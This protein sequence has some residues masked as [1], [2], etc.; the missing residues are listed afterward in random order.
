M[1]E[2][3]CDK[4][5]C[6]RWLCRSWPFSRLNSWSM[7]PD[8]SQEGSWLSPHP[9]HTAAF[10]SRRWAS[11][12]CMTPFAL[13]YSRWTWHSKLLQAMVAPWMRTTTIQCHQWSMVIVPNRKKQPR[14][15]SVCPPHA[16]VHPVIIRTWA[17]TCLPRAV[18]ANA[19]VSSCIRYSSLCKVESACRAAGKKKLLTFNLQKCST[20]R[21]ISWGLSR[22]HTSTSNVSSHA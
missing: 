22:T 3:L 9:C 15:T 12:R 14:P 16:A 8:W 7:F 20:R 19:H 6:L 1:W 2:E 10:L 21:K 5:L 11:M 17:Y 4:V 18:N 13:C